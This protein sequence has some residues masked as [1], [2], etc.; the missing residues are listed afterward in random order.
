MNDRPPESE[1]PEDMPWNDVPADSDVV[2][3]TE[4]P[5]PAEVVGDEGEERDVSHPRMSDQE[6]AYHRD[7]LDQR[8]AEEEPE[9]WS[10]EADAEAGGLQAPEEGEPGL[11]LDRGEPDSDE[12]RRADDESAE[13]AAIHVRDEERSER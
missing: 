2:F 5:D 8:L 12:P 13:E 9:R 3:G 6:S 1:H 11:F 10:V 4:E 7:T